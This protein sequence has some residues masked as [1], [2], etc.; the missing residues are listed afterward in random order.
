FFGYSQ[1]SFGYEL[2]STAFEPP[3]VMPLPDTV[4]LLLEHELGT[5]PSDQIKVG[6]PVKTGQRLSWKAGSQPGVISSV[7]GKISGVTAQ[8]GDYGKKLTA[9]TI[10]REGDDRWDEG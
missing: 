4:I 8:Y 1:I 7:T 3:Q 5:Q 2:L 10:T 9:I 6:A